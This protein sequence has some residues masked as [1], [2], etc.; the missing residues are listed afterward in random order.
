MNRKALIVETAALRTPEGVPLFDIRPYVSAYI[1][2]GLD[3]VPLE[4]RGK[5]P[6]IRSWQTTSFGPVDFAADNNVG[7][8]LGRDGL[9]DVDLDCEEAIAVAQE[10]LPETG[11]VFGRRSARASHYFFRL[12]PP[13]AS[14]KLMDPLLGKGAGTI[15][16][17]RS[18]TGDGSVGYQ[19][20]APGS[21]HAGTGEPIEFE[22][23]ATRMVQN[24][25]A[26]EII[27]A[28]HRIG[29]AVLFGRY[30]PPE[31]SGRN[32]AF[33]AIAGILARNG[34]SRQD[35]EMLNF[36][37]YRII[38]GP[39]ADRRMCMAEVHATYEKHT[40]GESTTG[41]PRL[42][43]LIKE[44]AVDK[45]LEWLGIAFPA[46][47]LVTPVGGATRRQVGAPAFLPNDTGNADRLVAAHGSDLMFCEQRESLA[48]WTGFRWA[49]D[50]SI[51]VARLAESVMRSA[52]AEAAEIP[53]E[54]KRKRF[55]RFVNASLSRAG[56]S[57]MVDVSKR[58]LRQVGAADFD[59]DPYLLNFANGTLDLRTGELRG[60]QRED[61]I[62]KLIPYEFDAGA[63]CPVFHQFLGRIMGAGP[64]ATTQESERADSLIAY[65]QRLFGCA[66]T[67]KPEKL[68]A[69]LWGSGNNGK[70]TLLEVIRAAMGD[71]EY[72]GQLQIE[73]LM[74]KQS[75]AG[76]SNTINSDLAGLQGCRFVTASEPDKGMKFSVS[77]I[78][79]ITGLSKIKARYLREN[80]F[81]FVPTH[82]LFI[83][84]NDRPII[85]DPHD[86]V[87]NRVKLISF[88]VRIPD[89]EIDTLLPEKLRRELPGIMTW[90]V[91]G[92]TDYIR[93]GV[94]DI[95]EVQSATEEY[96]Q[97]SDQ[98]K[99]FLEDECVFGASAWAPIARLWTAFQ[100]WEKANAVRHP[101]S[102][103]AF[104]ERIQKLGC[105]K[106]KKENGK[107]RAWAGLALKD[108]V[109]QRDN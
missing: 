108:P 94:E 28:V 73:S 97:D 69:I 2:S 101:M 88:T 24:A 100:S 38:W 64:D 40:A 22:S 31:K 19:T 77:R 107:T 68:L 16:E 56:I 65:L 54:D 39:H 3:V 25:D 76:A 7:I 5:G 84:C 13:A 27:R 79:Y 78:K 26:D 50:K 75:D 14:I 92:A 85:S 57:N 41:I 23:G 45:A 20:V 61:L 63:K 48:V 35:A 4:P 66:L 103:S 67:G 34:W 1:A 80:P 87:W 8:R 21:I 46:I 90:L 95:P 15:V 9:A 53:E 37:I 33:L 70:T 10:L 43:E 42:K 102:K 93:C 11:F 29:A 109:G 82:K 98:L 81:T 104:D 60:P 83:D 86:A 44:V 99:D 89:Q 36:A 72:A 32:E 18:L 58:K 6:R 51:L 74:T 47:S 71:E 52:Y 59:K 49:L 105:K 17:L 55:L 30:F 12:D 91:K 106:T 62:T 96:R